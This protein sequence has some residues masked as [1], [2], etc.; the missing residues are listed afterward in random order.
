[1]V[2]HKVLRGLRE[3]GCGILR[4]PAIRP[5]LQGA[6]QRL[7]HHVLGQF[8]PVHAEPAGQ[9]GDEP[10]ALVAEKVLGDLPR[11]PEP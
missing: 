7:L 2:E 4:H 3:P 5:R 9:S 10:R 8:E 6:H 1:M 11:G